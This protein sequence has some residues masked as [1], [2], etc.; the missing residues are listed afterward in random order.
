MKKQNL[1]LLSKNTELS[2]NLDLVSKKNEE[3][4][5]ELLVTKTEAENGMRWT[6][7][8]I[9]L[10][11]IHRN[12]TSE[13]HGIGLDKTNPQVKNPN[14]DCLCMHC[15]LVGHKSHD[16]QRKQTAHNKNLKSLRKPHHEKT[17]EQ[18][19]IPTVKSLPR[20]ARKKS[21]SSIF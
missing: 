5:K 7:S 18:K 9:L 4:T 17:N 15:G 10:D 19:Q 13:R 8:S 14:I 21:Y 6:S 20:W 2:K 1:H 3:L 11:N 12:R 16:C